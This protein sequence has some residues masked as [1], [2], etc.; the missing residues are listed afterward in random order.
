MLA[1]YVPLNLNTNNPA[2]LAE[3]VESNNMQTGDL[4]KARWAKP[5]ARRSPSQICGHLILTFSNLDAANRAKMEGL[6]ICNKR[7][8]VAK[9]KKEPI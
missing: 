2:H 1:Y 3:I 9:Y 4:L 5:P 7:V 8:S 6:V